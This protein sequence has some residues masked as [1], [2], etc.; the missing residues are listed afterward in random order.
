[1]LIGYSEVESEIERRLAHL[2]DDHIS[3]DEFTQNFRKIKLVIRK[4][5]LSESLFFPGHGNKPK[6]VA[7]SNEAACVVALSF[8]EEDASAAEAM[9]CLLLKK[10]PGVTIS[11]PRTNATS[12]LHDLD[13]ARVIIILLSPAYLNSKELVEE[14]NIALYRHRSSS[15]Q[16]VYP[17]QVSPLPPKPS[18]VRLLPY[19]FAAMDYSW[20]LRALGGQINRESIECLAE[21]NDIS[22]SVA[23]CLMDASDLIFQEISNTDDDE[24]HYQVLLNVLE[25]QHMWKQLLEKL[26]KEEGLDTLKRS[27]GIQVMGEESSASNKERGTDRRPVP[28]LEDQGTEVNDENVGT[29]HN[30]KATSQ[31]EAS[32]KGKSVSFS[33][34]GGATSGSYN[35]TK[36]EASKSCTV[37]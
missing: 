12:R 14:L 21:E 32:H 27:F 16:V 9:K 29:A 25:V 22:A 36:V 37:V 11:L 15:H 30:K 28:K 34:H 35:L 4:N 10:C 7:P 2:T 23:S 18:Y 24:E 13:V 20:M 1:M 33:S 26:S 17:I 3:I 31:H 8:A 6:S 19:E 5:F